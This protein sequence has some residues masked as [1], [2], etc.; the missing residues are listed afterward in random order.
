MY[1]AVVVDD[2]ATVRTLLTGI[3]G[4][5]PEIQVIG[6]ARDGEEGVRMVQELRP[7]VV[8]MDIHMPRMNGFEATKEIMITAPTPVV[9]VTA[10][11][12]VHDVET[13]MDTLRTGALALLKKPPGPESPEFEESARQLLS[14]VKAMAQ[15]KVIRHH[16]GDGSRAHKKAAVCEPLEGNG[17]VA[18]ATST[19]GPQ[20]L[21]KLLAELPRDFPLPILVVQHISAGFTAGF[22]AWLASMVPLRVKVAQADEPL[23]ASTVYLAPEEVHLGMTAAGTVLLSDDPPIGGFRP[24]GTF[25]FRS[26]AAACGKGTFAMILTG[27]GSDGVEGLQAVRNAGGT[28][29]AQDEASSVVYG[30]PQAAARADL[31]DLVLSLDKMPGKLTEL[32][33]KRLGG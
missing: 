6:T 29:I 31:A 33:R 9:I 30:M 17:A 22:A 4:S 2:S 15:V 1:R 13:A 23:C 25:L 18:I 5:D 10:S 8:T 24:S 7:D 19:G 20:T 3:L 14:T 32:V 16:R 21:Q 28:I 12:R 27:M 26:T 11:T